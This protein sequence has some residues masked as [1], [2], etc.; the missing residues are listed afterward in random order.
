MLS[1]PSAESA[2]VEIARLAS[3]RSAIR[4]LQRVVVLGRKRRAGARPAGGSPR[5]AC[6]RRSAPRSAWSPA[7]DDDRPGRRAI[8]G[9]TRQHP[10]RGVPVARGGVGLRRFE[11]EPRAPAAS[12]LRSAIASSTRPW[13][14]ARSCAALSPELVEQARGAPRSPGPVRRQGRRPGAAK[15][16]SGSPQRARSSASSRRAVRSVVAAEQPQQLG[17]AR[18]R[19]PGASVDHRGRRGSPAAAGPRAATP[20]ARWRSRRRP[21]RAAPARP[22]ARRAGRAARARGGR[23]RARRRDPAAPSAAA[24]HSRYGVSSAGAT[25]PTA[26]RPRARCPA[27]PRRPRPGARRRRS[28]ELVGCGRER[29]AHLRAGSR[30]SD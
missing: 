24:P 19:A 27:A 18:L 4:R 5:P 29:G 30:R 26:R 20:G 10:A 1:A 21:A 14:A 12:V 11:P 2:R 3:T 13:R 7:P 28:A 17:R 9:Q 23:P 6:P 15:P 25:G 8:V 16:P 22:P